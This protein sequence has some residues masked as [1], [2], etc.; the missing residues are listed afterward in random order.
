[1][2]F[3][4]SR[5]HGSY[6]AFSVHRLSGVALAIFLPVHLYVISLLL[7]DPQALDLFLDWTSAPLAKLTESMLIFL[8]GAHL[9]G[10]IRILL[11]EW[12]GF[13]FKQVVLL[14]FVAVFAICC[15]IAYL[16]AVSL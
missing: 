1:M 16:A 12:F 15:G 8:A 10:G 6:I 9:A 4:K 7:T 11:I 3:L 5:A 13:S 14:A 2:S